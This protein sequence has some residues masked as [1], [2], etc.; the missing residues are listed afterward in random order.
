MRSHWDRSGT[1][2]IL[3][4]VATALCHAPSFLYPFLDG[5][6]ST[7]AAIAALLGEG[8][9]LYGDGGVDFKLYAF[10]ESRRDGQRESCYFV[11]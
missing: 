6:E 9:K 2:V 10:G 7:F 4:F 8:G 3:V 1:A 11:G 5:D